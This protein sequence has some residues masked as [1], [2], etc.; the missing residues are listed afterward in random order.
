MCFILIQFIKKI[1]GARRWG[2]RGER[3]RGSREGRG[4]GR[5]RRRE[6]NLHILQGA[7]P[8]VTQFSRVR[9]VLGTRGHS[10]GRKETCTHNPSRVAEVDSPRTDRAMMEES[11][12]LVLVTHDICL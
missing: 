9:Q 8:C 2:G 6:L 5:G 4:G 1:K 11:Q 12:K 7:A 10:T 3:E